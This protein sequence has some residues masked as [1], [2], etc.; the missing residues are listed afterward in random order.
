LAFIV[1]G[2]D[3]IGLRADILVMDRHSGKVLDTAGPKLVIP[4]ENC[5]AVCF[6]NDQ[7]E[8]L[9]IIG[10]CMY[11]SSRICSLFTTGMIFRGW[12]KGIGQLGTIPCI[13]GKAVAAKMWQK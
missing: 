13:A 5:A 1:G 4:R 8:W 6:S 2:F 9:A 7:G 11:M 10:G 3:G 12:P